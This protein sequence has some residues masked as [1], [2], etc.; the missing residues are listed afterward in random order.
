MKLRLMMSVILF[1]LGAITSL[2]VHNHYQSAPDSVSPD[3]AVA[4]IRLIN[5][6][7][8]EHIATRGTGFGSLEEVLNHR[9]FIRPENLKVAGNTATF[10][11][12]TLSLATAEDG[13]QFKVFLVPQSGCGRAYFSDDSFLIY[14]GRAFG[15]TE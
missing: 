11:N 4:L 5:I 15:C 3:D 7:Q 10:K 8:A 2:A 12:Y 13:K 1:G 14:E 6:V 9:S